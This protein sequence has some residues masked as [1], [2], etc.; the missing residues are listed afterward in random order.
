VWVS[1]FGVDYS[2]GSP[3]IK[4]LKNAKVTFVGRYVS[5][6]GA[7][8]NL[9]PAEAERL[10]EAGID[11]AVFF[12]TSRGFMISDRNSGVRDANSALVQARACGMPD[13]R[14]IYFALDTDP[15][16][17]TPREWD[18]VFAY[19]DGAAAV[20]G[21]DNVGIYGGRLAI[22]KALGAGKAR[23][24]WQT[25]SWS[26]GWSDK[27]HVRQFEHDLSLGSGRVDK[28]QAMTD[29]F[30]QW[31]VGDDMPDEQT[32]KK[33]VRQVLDAERK[34]AWAE[35]VIEGQKTLGGTLAAIA[36]RQNRLDDEIKKLR[37][38]L[39]R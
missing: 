25:K 19:L 26:D 11:I 15:N 17:L 3:T 9:T 22:D 37:Q 21:R 20:I 38:A 31:R 13:G 7:A 16:P 32:F 12:Q 10:T 30:G 35:G 23:W 29:D 1:R 6:S 5:T 4:E 34:D 18:A 39:A 24:G 33:W 2:T 27:A 14:P 36:D 8:K 28:N